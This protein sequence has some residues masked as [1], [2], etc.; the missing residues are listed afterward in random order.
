MSQERN[1]NTPPQQKKKLPVKI[2]SLVERLKALLDKK[3]T[4]DPNPGDSQN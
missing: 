4:E 2:R 3:K 1:Q